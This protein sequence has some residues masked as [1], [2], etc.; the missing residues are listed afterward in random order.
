[1]RPPRRGGRAPAGFES[2]RPRCLGPWAVQY[3][4]RRRRGRY[5]RGMFAANATPRFVPR[6]LFYAL[7]MGLRAALC[8][9]TMLEPNGWKRRARLRGELAA[10]QAA[11]LRSA[12]QV[13]QLTQEIASLTHVPGA[14]E[15]AIRD[16]LGWVR[17]AQEI[18]IHFGAR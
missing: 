12:A 15:H 9:H 10:L 13:E 6:H 4:H 14:Q 3:L 18:V 16:E 11:N 8:L 5:P 7:A 2:R 17:D 1:M